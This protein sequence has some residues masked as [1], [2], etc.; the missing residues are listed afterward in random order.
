MKQIKEDRY[1]EIQREGE[2]ERGRERGRERERGSER[3]RGERGRGRTGGRA[4]EREREREREEK[5][6]GREREREREGG[7]ERGKEKETHRETERQRDRESACSAF[8]W[9]TA[10]PALRTIVCAGAL[11]CLGV[12]VKQDLPFACLCGSLPAEGQCALGTRGSWFFLS[13]WWVW[14][15]WLLPAT[16]FQ[17]LSQKAMAPAARHAVDTEDAAS[18]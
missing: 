5:E 2:K 11:S 16:L 1:R 7:R 18:G 9:L 8:A 4:R 6:R 14:A 12:A 15:C 10:L 3:E 13:C 17:S